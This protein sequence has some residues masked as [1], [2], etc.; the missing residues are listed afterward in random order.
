MPMSEKLSF[1]IALDFNKLSL[2]LSNVKAFLKLLTCCTHNCLDCSKR[3]QNDEDM[4]VKS[5]QGQ[6]LVTNH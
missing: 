5:K 3:T 6:C 1:Q 2:Y 4:V